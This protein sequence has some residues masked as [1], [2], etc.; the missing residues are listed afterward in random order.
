MTFEELHDKLLDHETVL[1]REDVKTITP[2]ITS[3]YHQQLSN[4]HKYK[5]GSGNSN[6]G[7]N[8]NYENRNFQVNAHG[9]AMNHSYRPSNSAFNGNNFSNNGGK[10]LTNELILSTIFIEAEFELWSIQTSVPIV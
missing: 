3:Q 2:P 10:L 7:S 5:P 6:R 4:N 1:K 9:N 8:N